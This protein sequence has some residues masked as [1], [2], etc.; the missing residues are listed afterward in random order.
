M[1]VFS[2]LEAAQREGFKWQCFHAEY[3]MHIVEMDRMNRRG[4]REKAMAFACVTPS[5]SDMFGELK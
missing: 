2:S 1:T 5:D 3:K 4:F